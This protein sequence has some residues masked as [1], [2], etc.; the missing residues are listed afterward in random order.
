[1]AIYDEQL[2]KYLKDKASAEDEGLPEDEKCADEYLTEMRRICDF[3]VE[4]SSTIRVIFPLY[5]LHDERHI[6]G[7]MRKITDLLG[8]NGMKRLSRDETAMLILAA[9]CHD[10]GMSCSK[11]QELDL[12]NDLVRLEAYYKEH[13]I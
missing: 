3:A 5:T 2:W 7:V 4:R 11:E 6:C 12:Q 13:Y 8:E 10:L 9:C 1:M